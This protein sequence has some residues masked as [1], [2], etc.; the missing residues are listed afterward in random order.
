[1]PSSLCHKRAQWPRIYWAKLWAVPCD[2]SPELLNAGLTLHWLGAQDKQQYLLQHP[3]AQWACF[4]AWAPH[5]FC[6]LAQH[7]LQDSLHDTLHF[8]AHAWLGHKVKES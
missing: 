3:C 2:L 5:P 8:H 7:S 6:T 1:M 4:L